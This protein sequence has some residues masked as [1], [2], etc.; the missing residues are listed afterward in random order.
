MVIRGYNYPKHLGALCGIISRVCASLTLYDPDLGT[1][2]WNGNIHANTSTAVLQNRAKM[3][4]LNPITGG[5]TDIK[6]KLIY[7]RGYVIFT[8]PIKILSGTLFA[9]R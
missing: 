6:I 8:S 4:G 2:N 7:H 5:I 9:K 3:G 1:A